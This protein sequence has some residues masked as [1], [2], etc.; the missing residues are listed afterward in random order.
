MSRIALF[1]CVCLVA[2]RP[3]DA[4]PPNVVLIFADDLGINDLRCDGRQDHV[5]PNLDRLASQGARFTSAYCSM[6]ICSASRAGLLTGKSP[7]RLHLTT[8]LPGRPDT[9]AQRLLHP[10][11]PQQLA[12]EEQTLA[13]RLRELGYA[14]A[15]VGKW[16]LGG[17][18]HLPTDQ[19]FDEYF[20]G[21]S[22]TRPG[23][24]EGGKG[25]YG[26][27][28]RAIEF[29]ESHREKPFFLYLPHNN[30]H[31]VLAARPELIEKHREAFNPV[32]AAMV[33]TLDDSVGLLLDALDRNGLA[34][35]TIVIFTSDNGGLH[36]L[37]T[38][39]TPA[40]HNTP[41]RAGKG[42]LYEGGLRVP[43]IVRWP[44]RIAPQTVD[45][46]MV[47]ADW[48]PTLLEWCGGAAPE[49]IDGVS[50]AGALT[51][52]APPAERAFCFHFPHY[53][54]Q[55][56]RPAGSIRRGDWKL[57]AHYE[58]GRVEL[59]DLSQDPGEGDDI[60]AVNVDRAAALHDELTAWRD[61]VGAQL[62][63]PN[64]A[65]DPALAEPIDAFDPSR[66]RAGRTAAEMAPLFED[67]RDAMNAAVRAA[68]R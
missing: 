49:G 56:G 57:V 50:I 31:V 30:P 1:V 64:P 43:Q 44:G 66:V 24:D 40:T 14:T 47:H 58:T 10:V 42:Y 62:N 46:P 41:W 53:T 4:A 29:I 13:E 35:N 6:S 52:G 15:C 27:T 36:V 28:R 11:I 45:W 5:T 51:S 60:A 12:L 48:L 9:P 7:A 37:E 63:V 39:N 38:P 65:F 33:E 23:P 26:L 18:G 21:Q 2:V 16:H 54:N 59:F 34:E 55:G 20:P 19:G 67:W 68:Q 61:A 22:D 25:E 32:Y 8:F 3:A 17:P